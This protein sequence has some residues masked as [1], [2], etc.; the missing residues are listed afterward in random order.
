LE[1]VYSAPF[2]AD[3][4]ENALVKLKKPKR[5]F[6]EEMNPGAAVQRQLDAYNAKDIAA[7]VCAAACRAA[8]LYLIVLLPHVIHAQ[9]SS[10]AFEK[11]ASARAILC[12]RLKRTAT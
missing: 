11:W 7:F 3:Q 8:L 10:E 2:L 1:Y 9:Q 5:S 12:G 4:A 6:W